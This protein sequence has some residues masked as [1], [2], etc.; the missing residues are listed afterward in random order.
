MFNLFNKLEDKA[1]MEDNINNHKYL[2]NIVDTLSSM[3][4]FKEVKPYTQTIPNT[5]LN[6]LAKVELETLSDNHKI[7]LALEKQATHL[8]V[9]V[10]DSPISSI[11]RIT[12]FTEGMLLDILFRKFK[13]NAKDNLTM[14]PIVNKI[15]DSYPQETTIYIERYY[16][17]HYYMKLRGLIVPERT[18]IVDKQTKHVLA[19]INRSTELG[20]T[21]DVILPDTLQQPIDLGYTPSKEKVQ[22]FIDTFIG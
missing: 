2:E 15:K 3:I 6:Y 20:Y 16:E 13:V 14:M 9:S 22:E 21:Y 17:E 4:D 1:E 19:T 18:H 10:D 7:N 5:G 12:S 11:Y 8:N